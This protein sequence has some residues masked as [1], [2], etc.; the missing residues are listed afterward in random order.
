VK[1]YYFGTYDV[2][3]PR[4]RVMLEGLRQ[5]GVEVVEYRTQLWSDTSHK[6]AVAQR[7]WTLFREMGQMVH[8]YSSLAIRSAQ[9]GRCD[10]VV[11]AH[12]G[13]LD[14]VLTAW[15]FRLR[16]IPIIW[17]ALV[18]LYDTVIN[19]R[20]LLTGRSFW[21]WWLKRMDWLSGCLADVILVDTAQNRT[22]WQT[23]FSVPSFKLQVVPV[24]AE[25]VF[26]TPARTEAH[27]R[28]QVLF[29]GKYIPLHGIE[30]IIRAAK[31]LELYKHISWTMIGI[32]QQ[33][34]HIDELAKTLRVQ[35]VDF[36]DWVPYQEI[37]AC[38]AQA[39]LCLGVFG[40]TDKAARVVPNKVY[41]ALASQCPVITGDTP[42]AR[43][44]LLRE[45]LEGALLVPC[46]SPTALAEAVLELS[47]S[48]QRCA[49]L[50]QDG[51][52]LYQR[53]YSSQVIGRQVA[54]LLA[55]FV[56]S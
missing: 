56:R 38:I 25:D 5:A 2:Y 7:P 32:G 51:F 4:T 41:Q 48:P 11:Y 40:T 31:A 39:D 18:S 24:G 22:F 9:I 43:D 19:D 36:V 29:Y 16:H 47:R 3:Q 26:H 15:W 28:F 10:A 54:D 8:V 33:R 55:A 6:V 12:L 23:R 34:P 30:T 17:D 13:Q 50:A 45:G 49:K 20:G 37:P 44:I 52:E 53:Y 35:N 1:V 42:A 46:A 27:S 21:G 14:L